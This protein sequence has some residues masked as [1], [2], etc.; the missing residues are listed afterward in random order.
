M[1]QMINKEIINKQNKS[2]SI[3][4][5][6]EGDKSQSSI[7]FGGYDKEGFLN[8]NETITMVADSDYA[9]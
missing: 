3:Y 4:I 1:D 5:S 9:V 7:L 6:E 2:F 8:P